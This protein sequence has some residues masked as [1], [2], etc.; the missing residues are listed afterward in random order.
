MKF[1]PFK[2]QQVSDPNVSKLVS[3]I[4]EWSEQFQDNPLLSGRLITDLEITTGSLKI[5]HG[6][7]R[8][9]KGWIIVSKDA[10]ANVWEIRKSDSTITFDS[11]ATVTVSIWIF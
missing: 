4:R 7:K 6:L 3:N 11:S 9:P 1:K 2:Q 5:S 10:D 8:V